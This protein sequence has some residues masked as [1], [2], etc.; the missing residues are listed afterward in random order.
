MLVSQQ[1]SSERNRWQGSRQAG[2][3]ELRS[4]LTELTNIQEGHRQRLL[5][6]RRQLARV[7]ALGGEYSRVEMSEYA[8]AAMQQPVAV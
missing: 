4:Q 5:D 1:A 7:Q 3:A 8:V 6:L 2:L